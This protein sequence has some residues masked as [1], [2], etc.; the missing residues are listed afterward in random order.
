MRRGHGHAAHSPI[1]PFPPLASCP[2]ESA[3]YIDAGLTTTFL[4]FG[5]DFPLEAFS[6]SSFRFFGKFWPAKFELFQQ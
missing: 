3:C 6:P 2:R 5:T 1:H 4:N